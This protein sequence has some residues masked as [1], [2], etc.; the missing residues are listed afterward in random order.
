MS[1]MLVLGRKEDRLF[2]TSL[3]YVVKPSAKDE[4]GGRGIRCGRGRGK[5][6]GLL[7]SD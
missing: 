2:Q 6:L 5:E 3:G 4:K 1:V 7:G